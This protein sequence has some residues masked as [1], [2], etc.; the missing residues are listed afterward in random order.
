MS[1]QEGQAVQGQIDRYELRFRHTVPTT[2]GD[3]HFFVASDRVSRR[4][5]ILERVA[6][7]L[8]PEAIDALRRHL[9]AHPLR[10]LALPPESGLQSALP[11]FLHEVWQPDAAA[12]AAGLS[13]GVVLLVYHQAVSGPLAPPAEVSARPAWLRDVLRQL[14]EILEP[15]HRLQLAHGELSPGA[16][17]QDQ[18]GAVRLTGFAAG[19]AITRL[20]AQ[21]PIEPAATVAEDMAALQ[22]MLGHYAESAGPELSA[23]LLATPVPATFA[24]LAARLVEPETAASSTAVPEPVAALQ[25]APESVLASPVLSSACCPARRRRG[26]AAVIP[27]LLLVAVLVMAGR[28]YLRRGGSGS[29]AWGSEPVRVVS[30]SGEQLTEIR[31]WNRLEEVFAASFTVPEG[32]TAAD[33]LVL[34]LL[35][36]TD[37]LDVVCT[38]GGVRLLSPERAGVSQLLGEQA[39]PLQPGERLSVVKNLAMLSVYRDGVQILAAQISPQSWRLLKWQHSRDFAGAVPA[40]SYQKIGKLYFSDDFMHNE[41]ELGEWKPSSG[42][43]SVHS[44]ATPVRSA[45]PFSLLGKGESAEIQTG[46][47]FWR[48]YQF[49]IAVQPLSGSDFGCRFARQEQGGGYELSWRKGDA[50][51]STPGTLTLERVTADER[52]VLASCAVHL[53]PQAWLKLSVRQLSAQLA[54]TLDGKLVLSAFDPE[55]LLGGGVSLLSMGGEGTVFDDAR[56]VPCDTLALSGAELQGGDLPWA[57]SRWSA[58]PGR[59]QLRLAAPELANASFAVDLAP[60]PA[61]LTS[62]TLTVRDTGLR[63]VQLLLLRQ[64]DGGWRC[65]LVNWQNLLTRETLSEKGGVVVPA[66][67]ASRLAVHV[68]GSEAWAVLNGETLCF[69][70]ALPRQESGL[71]ALEF[72]GLEASSPSPVQALILEPLLALPPIADKVAM[73]R[74]EVSM[75]EW[76]SPVLEWIADKDGVTFWHRT[77]FWKDFDVE[78]DLSALAGYNGT[79]WGLAAGIPDKTAQ[80]AQAVVRLAY[81]RDRQE[82]VWENLSDGTVLRQS[83]S[84]APQSLHLQK[85]GDRLLARQDGKVLWNQALPVALRGLCLIGRLGAGRDDAWAEAVNALG[86]G[87]L[88]YSFQEAPSAWIPSAGVWEIT[89]RWQCDPRWSFF[90][91]VN[92]AGP[93]CLWNKFEHGDNVSIDFF[94]GPKMDRDRGQKYE[95]AG[96]FGLALACDGRD[97]SSGYSFLFG[98]WNNRGSQIVR[99]D[100]IVQENKWIR[101]LRTGAIHRQWF[102]M[103]VRKQGGSLSFWVNGQIAATYEDPEPLRG[104]HFAIWTWKNG[105][106]A[107]QFRISS[108]QTL[109]A[110]DLGQRR[111]AEPRTPYA[112]EEK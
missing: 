80:T 35:G 78:M 34:S 101:V 87:F 88:V 66:T 54:V 58:A 64:E 93:A 33:A 26:L 12:Q 71:A 22:Q 50:A 28:F 98:G 70:D 36:T 51:Y 75:R 23:R 76:N 47:W 14:H 106:M 108:D 77:D 72:G 74:H 30:V 68:R 103:K 7:S 39:S 8:A 19:R 3:R 31:S 13:A 60:L 17:W 52:R 6:P 29:A 92:L 20:L 85:H 67:T 10:R 32:L 46:L 2:A 56:V 96:D 55:P 44:L 45:N 107:A 90:S 42:S 99:G 9:G 57:V 83:V 59:R 81:H 94:V 37:R 109:P 105:M 69:S 89:N 100:K 40:L 84:R 112:Q 49:S 65:E 1:N 16:L 38:E 63:K 21:Q 15:A 111:Q 48:N 86:D 95:Y 41:G 5:V 53:Q 102:H 4:Q 79:A 11:A 24:E 18:S 62:V 25:S 104:R 82:I 97:I 91:G 110:S 61:E 73:F 27:A 43:W